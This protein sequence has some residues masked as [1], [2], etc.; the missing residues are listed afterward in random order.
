[1]NDW[2]CVVEHVHVEKSVDVETIG[3]GL[4]N[5]RAWINGIIF[6]GWW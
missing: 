2:D 1:L 4:F 3:S 5:L 6:L